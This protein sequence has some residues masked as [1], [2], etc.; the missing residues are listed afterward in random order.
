M[1]HRALILSQHNLLYSPVYA[2]EIL[3]FGTPAVHLLCIGAYDVSNV[4]R[5]QNIVSVACEE[6]YWMAWRWRYRRFVVGRRNRY[7]GL[8]QSSV[9]Y[10]E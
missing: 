5:E 1:F 6:I 4:F 7:E 9:E 3:R 2:L 8:V 10:V